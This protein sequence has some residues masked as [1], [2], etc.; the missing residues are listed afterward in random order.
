MDIGSFDLCLWTPPEQPSSKEWLWRKLPVLPF[1]RLDV[2]SYAVQPDGHIL[3]STKSGA[4]AAT[5]TFDGKESVWKLHGEWALPFTDRGHCDLSLEAFV[6]LSKDPETFGYLYSCAVTSTGTDDDTGNRLRPSPDWKRSK[7]VYMR[8]GRFC[9][10]ECVSI[11]DVRADQV[12]LEEP[13][14]A[15][16]VPQRS[17]YMYRLMTF[18]LRYD[19]KGDL[20][21]K[22]C[23]VHCYNLPHEATT[24][25]M[26]QDPVVFWL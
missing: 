5:F 16:G 26:L 23:R 24:E 20:K 3:V 19:M 18:S 21:L 2:S 1:D 11:D 25:Y 4:T 10:V 6:G 13:G 17:R 12:L 15:G 7:E 8:R 9:L 22:H 14:A